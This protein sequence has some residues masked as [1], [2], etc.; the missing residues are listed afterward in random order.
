M[1][2]EVEAPMVEA[3]IVTWNKRDYVTRLLKRLKDIDYPAKRLGITVVDNHSTDGTIQKIEAFYP[4]VN[5]IK[6]RE[7]LGGVQYRYA[8]G[9]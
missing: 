8:V 1:V 3:I 4:S 2:T 9:A 6:N 7:N 5:L